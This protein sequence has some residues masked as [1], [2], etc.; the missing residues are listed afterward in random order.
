MPI[1]K[2]AIKKMRQDRKREK[3]NR[4]KREKV[5]G[6]L[7]NLTKNPSADALSTAFS[8]LDRAAKKGL[9]PAGRVDR[10]KARLSKLLTGKKVETVKQPSVKKKPTKKV[11]A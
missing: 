6:V 1:I 7:K 5:K 3:I 9:I 11:S 2:S 8:A 10:K 4:T